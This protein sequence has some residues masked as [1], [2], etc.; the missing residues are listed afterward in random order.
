MKKNLILT[1]LLAFSLS[2]FGQN[3]DY[4]SDK[5]G[6]KII[7][8]IATTYPKF[9][10]NYNLI[11]KDKRFSDYN[12][13]RG[14]TRGTPAAA[15]GRD[16][17]IILDVSF[18]EN[19]VQNY[20]D[21]RLV[22]VL[23]HELGHL[24]YFMEHV[25][26]RN[27]EDNEKYAFEYSLKKTKE[28][29]ENG[30]CEPLLTGINFMK[31]RSESNNLND[32][33]TRALKRMVNEPLYKSY[34]NYYNEKCGKSDFTANTNINYSEFNSSIINGDTILIDKNVPKS[35]EINYIFLKMI[36]N[37]NRKL[38]LNILFANPTPIYMSKYV[39]KSDSDI[40][41]ISINKEN[42]KTNNANGMI[43]SVYET[44]VDIKLLNNLKKIVD[45][46]NIS[47]D[48]VGRT[49]TINRNINGDELI[50]LKRILSYF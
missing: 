11:K 26:D 43:S 1:F 19:R 25:F 20:D 3:G 45:T 37:K 28:I 16:R 34:I 29:A 5:E 13:V 33:H 21:N 49:Q 6:E 41:E 27:V 42:F 40:L 22:V 18:L 14:N 24:Y 4:V 15:N 9:Y 12:F 47:I 35:K 48:Y 39:L 50:S 32:P 44:E 8:S 2:V 10:K 31:I 36:N 38:H 17:T 7:E 23:Y 30:D 46:D